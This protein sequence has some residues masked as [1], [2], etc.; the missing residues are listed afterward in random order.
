LIPFV[1]RKHE[2]ANSMIN[3]VHKREE[4]FFNYYKEILCLRSF[5]SSSFNFARAPNS[6]GY[7][8]PRL[9]KQSLLW[10]I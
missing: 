10:R 2:T 6:H 4:G 3:Y 8:E 5:H 9:A 1:I 7:I